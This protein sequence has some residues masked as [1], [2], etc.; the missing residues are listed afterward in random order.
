MNPLI[1][2]VGATG[3]G[4][5]KLAVDLAKRFNGEII[6]GDAMQL[7]RG[8]PIITNK[9][10]EE[11]REDIKHHLIDFIGLEEETWRIGTFRDECLR[12]IQDIHSRGKIP[13]L[14]GGTS[15]YVQSVLFNDGL[16]DS[17]KEDSKQAPDEDYNVRQEGQSESKDW[18]ILDAPVETMLDKLREVDPIMADRWHIKEVRKIRRSLEI[19]LKTGRPA[20]EIYA[21]QQRQRQAAINNV[22][23]ETTGQLRYE[24][25]VFWM[26]AERETL[27]KRLDTRVEKMIEQGLVAEARS[28]FE[29]KESQDTQLDETRGIWV[30]IGLKELEPYFKALRA[31]GSS[32][33][34]IEALKQTCVESVKTS[35]RQYSSRQ[36]R[37]IRTKIWTALASL[38][39]TD[40]LYVLDA[41]DPDAWDRCIREPAERV[42]Q[43]FLGNSEIPEPESLSELARMTLE[44]AKKSH[45]KQNQPATFSKQMTC[46]VCHKTMMGEEQWDIHVR[47]SAHRRV[48]K[49][50]AKR[51]K[52]QEY[53]RNREMAEGTVDKVSTD[54][55]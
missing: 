46:E 51:A 21:E 29:Y 15:Y 6:N 17:G 38:S 45:E 1:T 30:S 22:E 20:S 44:D 50:A 5:S 36:T 35:T 13:I 4:K 24:T 40:R 26:H 42:A 31:G 18:P 9:I 23:G 48:M 41:T 12:V 52:R 39:A 25:L 27:Y 28:L 33:G 55:N 14:V 54:G 43:G 37:W 19:Y 47:G 11:E 7:Y 34:Q 32:E 10:P 8:L 49:S 2:V 3:T 53:L 16:V